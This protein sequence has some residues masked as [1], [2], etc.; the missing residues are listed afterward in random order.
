MYIYVD[1]LYIY[2]SI[3]IYIYIYTYIYTYIYI[4]IY[5]YISEFFLIFP[6]SLMV[7]TIFRHL[8]EDTFDIHNLIYPTTHRHTEKCKIT[9]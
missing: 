7:C 2:K 4:Y 5:V 8:Q 1:I 9:R 6:Q 3:Y